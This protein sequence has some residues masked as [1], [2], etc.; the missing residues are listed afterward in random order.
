[1]IW[2]ATNGY[3]DAIED[4]KVVKKITEMLSHLEAHN[5]KLIEAIEKEK[6]LS[7]EIKK[8]LDHAVK[9]FFKK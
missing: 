2:A 6:A 4:T 7:D 1:M 5:K 3:L 9:E 8:D